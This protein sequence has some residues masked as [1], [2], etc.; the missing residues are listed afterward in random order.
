[1][2]TTTR[3]PI[4]LLDMLVGEGLL[5]KS[6]A[7]SIKN[8]VHEAWV[9]IGEVLSGL[10][11]LTTSQ[12]M[13]L[14]QMQA[15]EPHLRIGELAVR[16]GFCTEENVL[17]ALAMQREANPHPLEFL[18]ADYPCDRDRLWGV[19]VRYLKQVEARIAD[20]PSQV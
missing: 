12:L 4:G 16:E 9:P 15:G 11:H 19:V 18:L 10:G 1:M 20:L 2:T 5:T 7:L 6:A 8:R 13:D 17:D 14:V 3:L